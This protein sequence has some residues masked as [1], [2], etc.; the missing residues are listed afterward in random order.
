MI[1]EPVQDK[2]AT[3]RHFNRFFTR[4]IGVPREGLLHSPYSLTESRIIFELAHRND[5]T[6]SDLCRELGLD[7]GY[8]SRILAH[9]EQQGIVDKIRSE[10]DGRQRLLR[11]TTEGQ[12]AFTLLDQRSN[13]EVSEMLNDLSEA[14]QQRLL[15]AM[16]TIESVLTKGFKF[17]EP[18]ILRQHQPGDMGWVTHRHGVLYAQE[19]GWDESFEALV[20]QIVSDFIKNY[21]PSRERCWIAEMDGEIV[22]SVFVV[23][24]SDTVAKL[25][26][27]LVEPKARGLGLG[28]RLVEECVRFARRTGYTKMTLWTNNVLVTARHIYEKAGFVCVKQEPHHSFG[29]D[30]LGETW[31]LEL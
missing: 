29:H 27:L 5:L 18:F 23:Q 12:K 13:E 24:A 2:I 26:L 22:G 30:L 19:Y 4:E 9:L 16:H 20:A 17:S 7:P 25:R 3:V 15:K 11:L 31:E 8:L 28:N 1:A 10:N 6:A 14:D 21:N